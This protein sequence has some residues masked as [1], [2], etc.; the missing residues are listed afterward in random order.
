MGR[1]RKWPEGPEG[2]RLRKAAYRE[3]KRAEDLKRMKQVTEAVHT[4]DLASG[5]VHT[6]TPP[7]RDP[8]PVRAKRPGDLWTEEEYRAALAGRELSTSLAMYSR[9]G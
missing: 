7:K 2:D 6:P 8:E 5:R 9:N 4:R 3:K 1:P